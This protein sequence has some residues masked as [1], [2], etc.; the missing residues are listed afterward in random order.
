MS[1]ETLESVNKSLNS[2]DIMETPS[3]GGI[4]LNNINQRIKLSYGDESG[5]TIQSRENCY[6]KVIIKFPIK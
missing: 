6:T 3:S 5:I 2:Q 1:D 4:G